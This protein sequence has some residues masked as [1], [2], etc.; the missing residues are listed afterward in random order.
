MVT[1]EPVLRLRAE[2]DALDR[3]YTLGH[4]GRWTARRRA[5]LLDTCLQQL[6]WAADPPAEVTLAALGGYGR[7]LQLPAS[8]IDLLLLHDGLETAELERLSNALFYPLWD[9]GFALGQ[10]VRTPQECL[11]AGC[12]RLD[13]L[14]AMLDARPA[15]GD[16]FLLMRALTP[17]LEE[18]QTDPQAFAVRL[19]EEAVRRLERF[20]SCAHLLEPDL[21]EG[22]GGLRDVA[23]LGWLQAALG[24]P[25]DAAGLLAPGELRAVDDAEE[26][27]VRARSAVHLATGKRT[28][29]L[30]ADLQPEVA[31][32]MG[33]SDVPRL[34]ATDAL[35]RTLFEHARNVE[36][37]VASAVERLLGSGAELPPIADAAG[38]LEALADVAER[39]EVTTAG[40]H[41]AIGAADV[42]DLVAWT[43]AVRDAFLRILRSGAPGV[44]AF[45]LL[46]RTD[47]LG[48]YLPVWRD[49]RCRPQRDPYHR[50]TVDAHLT[51]AVE[52]MASLLAAGPDDEDP[53]L[54][55]ALAAVTRPD[56]LLL[57][58][59]LHDVGKVGEGNHVPIGARIAAEQL[60]SMG[61]DDET[62]ELAA[63]M[64]AEHLLLPDT[65]T[66]R[67]LTDENLV[68]DVAARIGTP[69]RLAALYLL[70]RADAA[71][72]GPAAWTPWRRTLVRELVV[73]VQH[74]LERGEMGQELAARLAGRVD[75][76]RDL[77]EAEPGAEVDRFVL[78]MP[79][80]YFLAI[81]PAQAARHFRTI[82]PPLGMHEVRTA[83]A[84][85]HRAGTYEVL[86]VAADRPGR[87]SW[88]TGAM[89]VG[90][91]S[92]LSA[93]VFTTEDGA[94]ADLFEVEGAFEA[95][96]TEARWREYRSTL[97]RTIDGSISLERRVADKRRHYP[98]PKVRTPVTVAVDNGASDFST[99]IEVGAPDRIGLLHDITRAFAD[100]KLDVHLAKVATFDGR[101]V[102]A[103]YVRDPL[104]RKIVDAEQL[105]EVE[106]ALRERLTP[107]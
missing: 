4:H 46:D 44:R 27:L 73:K 50:F 23:S 40:L 52:E 75:R 98:A 55:E 57:G 47:L 15:A 36:H 53:A 102:D 79:R 7:R 8:D 72:T 9:A 65:A 51:A 3:A 1:A 86:V 14:T 83:S 81:E 32:G 30:V 38:V 77:L 45:D 60:S 54:A 43:P 97:R 49:V 39:G 21:K 17:V 10:V 22:T 74:V 96:I 80:G 82:A 58:A 66:R 20:G 29:R 34:G 71:A 48:R 41:E 78:R 13:A 42:P 88:I 12:D 95:E 84:P 2:L 89:A 67:D 28:D 87:L 94:A 33:F 5:E 93:Q 18:L 68:L 104:G 16:A 62:R 106:R 11:E 92:I 63:F 70:A 24:R 26:F 100:L 25:L 31:A 64:V 61:L 35:M 101:V 90:G 107:G 6:W 103:F 91:I 105:A 59:M 99:V 37:A 76:V 85:G 69:E 19:R 56:A